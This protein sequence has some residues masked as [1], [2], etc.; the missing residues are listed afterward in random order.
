MKKYFGVMLDMSRNAVMKP[1]EVVA[2]A[3]ILKS[4]GYNMI[5]LYTEDTYEVDDEPYFGY[6][7]G[8]YTQKDLSYISSECEKMGVEVIPCIQTL[9][10]LNQ[11]LRWHK[12]YGEITDVGDILLAG[13]SRTYELI[14]NMFKSL[15]KSFTSNYVH[16]GMDEAEMI[17]RGKYFNKHGYRNHLEILNEH[18]SKVIEIAKRYNFKP[19]MWSDMFFKLAT[20]GEYYDIHANVTE[21][22]KAAVPKEVGLVYWDYYH[23]DKETYDG[24]FAAHQKFENEIWFAGGAWTWVGFAPGNG[25]TMKNSLP[26]MQSAREHGIENVMLTC[27]G[28]NGKECSFYS[29]LPALYAAKRFYDGETDM[30]TIKQEFKVITGE[31]FDTLVALDIPNFV[32]GNT[33]TIGNVSRYALYSD[34]FNGFLDCTCCKE[35]VGAEY[36]KHA[37]ALAALGKTSQYAYLFE[38][39][40]AL[41]HVLELKYDLG[42]R[43]RRAYQTGNKKALEELIDDYSEIV[44][45]LEK[46]Y[47][48]FRA[49]WYKENHPSGFDVQDVR[50]GGLK[51]RLI[52]CRDR[53]TEYINGNIEN[54]LEL[55]E[56]VLPYF[57]KEETPSFMVWKWNATANR[58]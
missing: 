42:V 39:E 16:I 41:C 27:W 57:Q 14:E 49:L 43:T 20:G 19:I 22:V 45:R 7:R 18:L 36:A 52:S 6:M 4:F 5:Q 35:G 2:Y 26:A 53:L 48:K 1:S 3:K 58:I 11:P 15:R 31:D 23:D 30:G 50:L 8:R 34:P 12:S 38:S 24:M 17:G 40:A 33:S 32:G 46:F 51:Q 29:I 9:A 37:E 28:D 13:E 54:I 55:E 10:H 25:F 47:E 44:V 21:E 56:E